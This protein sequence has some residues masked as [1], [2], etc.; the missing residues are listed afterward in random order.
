MPLTASIVFVIGMILA[1][2]ACWLAWESQSLLIGEAAV[3]EFNWEEYKKVVRIFTRMLDNVVE[4]NGLP[5]EKQRDE[6]MRKRR[7]GMG[8]L[9][10]G[11][12]LT[13]L[14]MK[15]GQ[16]DSVEFTERVAREMAVAGWEEGLELAREKGPAP[17]MDETFEVTGDMLRHRP[18][19]LFF[20]EAI[21]RD[22]GVIARV[23]LA[24][25]VLTGK[26]SAESTFAAEEEQ[27][28]DL[29]E[30]RNDGRAVAVRV[31]E[32]DNI[33]LYC[34]SCADD[35]NQPRFEMVPPEL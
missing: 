17:I 16:A 35:F 32:Y 30:F 13:M 25:G 5:L 22:I 3:A 7:H 28:V 2:V 20:R 23:P 19:G 11:S 1:G 9:G 8:F 31:V 4:I 21:A 26:M 33:R 24:S 29:D 6:I 15:Y 12:T 18:A 10:L 27:I 34:L 14:G